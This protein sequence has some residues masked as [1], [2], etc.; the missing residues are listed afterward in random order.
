MQSL[1]ARYL[2]RNAMAR[3]EARLDDPVVNAD[4]VEFRRDL[5]DQLAAVGEDEAA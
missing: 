2:H 5:L 4:V 1:D 3:R